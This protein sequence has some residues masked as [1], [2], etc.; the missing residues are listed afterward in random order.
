MPADPGGNIGARTC[1]VAAYITPWDCCGGNSPFPDAELLAARADRRRPLVSVIAWIS[2]GHF[3]G[4]A[5]RL[6]PGGTGPGAS[7][8]IKGDAH[9]AGRL[10]ASHARRQ[11]APSTCSVGRQSREPPSRSVVCRGGSCGGVPAVRAV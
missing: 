9:C 6:L 1:L 4:A 11:R 5:E 10:P 3:W 7:C 2:A 8:G